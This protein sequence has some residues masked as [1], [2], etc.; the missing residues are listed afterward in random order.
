MHGD[1]AMQNHIP[2]HQRDLL[3]I[4]IHSNCKYYIFQDDG[5]RG[6]SSHPCSYFYKTFEYVKILEIG[7]K[8]NLFFVGFF[9][10]LFLGFFRIF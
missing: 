3:R 6:T 2:Y 10:S 4:L 8:K 9:I 1:L 5:N 7:K